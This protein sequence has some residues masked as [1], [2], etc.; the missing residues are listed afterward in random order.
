MIDGGGKVKGMG[1]RRRKGVEREQDEEMDGGVK[2][3]KMRM[4]MRRKG[5]KGT[6]MRKRR[7]KR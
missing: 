1:I 4:T 5:L 6:D 7:R 2:G 3:S